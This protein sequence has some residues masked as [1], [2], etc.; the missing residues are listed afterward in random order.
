MRGDTALGTELT[1][2]T[3]VVLGGVS[4]F[5]GSGTLYGVLLSIL[6][7][8]NLRNGMGLLYISGDTQTGVIGAL[9]ILSVLVPNIAQEARSFWSRRHRAQRVQAVEEQKGG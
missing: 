6:I 4:I 3:M 9:L 5:G 8:L 1:V 7:V 2:I